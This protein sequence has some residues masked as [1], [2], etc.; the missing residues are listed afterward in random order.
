MIRQALSCSRNDSLVV[1]VTRDGSHLTFSGVVDESVDSRPL[2][3]LGDIGIVDRERADAWKGHRAGCTVGRS[4]VP[5]RVIENRPGS[6]W[7]CVAR[8]GGTSEGQYQLRH[9]SHTE[10]LQG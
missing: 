10:A 1:V 9:Q 3:S 5:C 6:Q 4:F 7:C 8:A 2:P